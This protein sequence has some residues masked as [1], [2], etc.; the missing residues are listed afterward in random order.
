M[1]EEHPTPAELHK[2]PLPT[3][4]TEEVEALDAPIM[5][6][7]IELA[8][9]SLPPSNTPCPDGL[10]GDWY[11][12][13][14]ETIA[15]KLQQLFS[16]CFQNNSLPPTIYGAHIIL[17]PKPGKD[18]K[19]CT[20][21]RSISLLNYDLKILAKVLATKLVK[22]LPDLVDIDQTGFMPGK[23]TDI[24]LRRVVTHLQLPH[25]LSQTRVIALDIEKAFDMVT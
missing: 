18:P 3:L 19:H 2:L 7:E 17:T 10:P 5:T 22:I 15:P 23:S 24:N 16:H 12:Q 21:Y 13:Y 14:A 6:L 11:K 9:A 1:F 20:S 8:I 4:S 25:S